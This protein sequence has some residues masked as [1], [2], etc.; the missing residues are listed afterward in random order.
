MDA[1]VI[2]NMI[3]RTRS[4]AAPLTAGRLELNASGPA[5]A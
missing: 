5:V 4:A 3:L 2:N 1:I